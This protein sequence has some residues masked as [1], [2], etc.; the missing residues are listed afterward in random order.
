MFHRQEDFILAFQLR[1]FAGTSVLTGNL[2]EFSYWLR[3]KEVKF[4]NLIVSNSC[5]NVRFL[6]HMSVLRLIFF[7]EDLGCKFLV[8]FL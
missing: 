7:N 1:P 3:I 8:F 4:V 5:K 2:Y 6:P